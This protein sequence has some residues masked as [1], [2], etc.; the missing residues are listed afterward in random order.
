[1]E[2]D[3]THSIRPTFHLLGGGHILYA[4]QHGNPRSHE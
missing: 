4:S 3:E 1:M 2:N